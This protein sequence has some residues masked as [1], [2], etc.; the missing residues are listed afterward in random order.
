MVQV[1]PAPSTPGLSRKSDV[2]PNAQ[3]LQTQLVAISNPFRISLL[4]LTK[5]FSAFLIVIP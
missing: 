3:G 4:L 1:S 2:S 5:V